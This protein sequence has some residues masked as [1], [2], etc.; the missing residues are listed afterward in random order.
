MLTRHF[1]MS[2]ADAGKGLGAAQIVWAL[3][4]A[5][6]AAWLVDRVSARGGAAGKMVLAAGVAL[7][8]IPSCMGAFM[9]AAGGAIALCGEVMAASAIYGATMLSVISE[10]LP[11]RAR[12]FAVALY[13]FVMTMI[14][15]SLGPF[16]VA[17]LTQHVFARPEAV[18]WS[19]AIVGAL[20]LGASAALG[21]VSAR[22]ARNM[23]ELEQ[24]E[25][26]IG[27]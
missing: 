22:A 14:G 7:A 3:V 13:A 11:A 5:G 6:C 19:M 4:G 27:R 15:G 26:D 9:P 1:H 23:A 24:Q 10:V 2:V 8:T 12:G 17:G 16:A 18:G 20:A 21:L 25:G